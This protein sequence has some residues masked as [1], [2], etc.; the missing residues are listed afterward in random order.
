[1]FQPTVAQTIKLQVQDEKLFL[2]ASHAY[3]I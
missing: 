1:M 3:L 2:E